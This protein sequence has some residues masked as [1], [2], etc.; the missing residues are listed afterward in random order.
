M[1]PKKDNQ[2]PPVDPEE[3]M[4]DD[5]DESQSTALATT[6][7]E[8]EDFSVEN[9]PPMPEFNTEAP[10]PEE[11]RG[12]PVFMRLLNERSKICREDGV[13]AGWYYSEEYGASD[14][15]SIE[16]LGY[17]Y[18]QNYFFRTGDTSELL[19]S[20]VGPKKSLLK[21]YGHP[22]G[23]CTT[24]TISDPWF[25]EVPGREP[26]RRSPKC[27]AGLSFSC[28]VRE[29][30]QIAQFDVFGQSS[31]ICERIGQWLGMYGA[32]NF[33]VTLKSKGVPSADGVNHVPI[34][35]LERVGS[36]R[37]GIVYQLECPPY[38]RTGARVIDGN[39]SEEGDEESG[40]VT[41]TVVSPGS[42]T[43][44]RNLPF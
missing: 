5:G 33:I 12:R 26:V 44:D 19:C 1:P 25:E 24:C 27:R 30:G 29:W 37:D 31:R 13:P 18:K 15:V 21:G 34:L 28:Y 7:A 39:D 22:G 43:E 32:G 23:D 35:R 8:P 36:E 16:P 17:L 2:P 10:D 6:N 4:D 20:A 41:G 9:R 3:F 11:M 38:L 40:V 42:G 14:E